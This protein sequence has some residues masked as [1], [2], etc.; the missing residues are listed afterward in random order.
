M[1]RLAGLSVLTVAL[2]VTGSVAQTTEQAV[3]EA[4]AKKTGAS[5]SDTQGTKQLG[6]RHVRIVRLSHAQGKVG[7]DR[8]AGRGPEQATQN[9]PMVE[10]MLL[11]TAND[12]GY[13][14]VEFEDGSTM[15][16]AP[17]TVV[18]FSQ[19]VTR[20]TGA[21]ATVVRVDRGTLYVDREN[22]KVDEFTL[23]AG[24]V[25]RVEVQPSTHI[26]L[27]LEGT[28]T[29]VA[30]FAGRVAVRG[31]T[32]PVMVGKNQTLLLDVADR[33]GASE[34]SKKVEESPYDGWDKYA[35]KYHDRPAKG[36][37]PVSDYP[38]DQKHYGWRAPGN[39]Y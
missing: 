19:L 14:E 1:N 7:I 25:R 35:Q 24:G 22:T 18:R 30:V 11:G 4:T 26:R 27:V 29:E 8:G 2:S 32:V 31:I 38:Y 12:G 37:S 5:A 33:S 36:D 10:G 20:S 17:G 34:L 23:V 28:K 9:M 16:L 6:D 39:A 15:R 21:K 13:A 3:T